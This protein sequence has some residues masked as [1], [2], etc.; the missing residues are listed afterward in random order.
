TRRL[1]GVA[2]GAGIHRGDERKARGKGDAQRRARHHHTP[3]LERLAE[4]LE[5]A[6][7]KLEQ[8]V[9]KEHAVVRE[10]D[11][12]WPRNATAADES[13]GGDRV[14][15]CTKRPCRDVCAGRREKTGDR[16]K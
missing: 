8:L 12:S 11:L 5:R 2:A 3:I 16:V 1:A 15:R 13:G 6:P 14:V 7:R 9:E 4:R 10:A